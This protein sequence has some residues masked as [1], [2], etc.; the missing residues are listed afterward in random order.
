MAGSS[1]ARTAWGPGPTWQATI[2]ASGNGNN[3]LIAGVPGARIV[4]ILGDLIASGAVTVT[5]Q[6]SGGT[7]L[8]GP[9]SPAANGGKIYP[10]TERGHF[11]T[12]TGEGLVLNLSGSVQVGGHL[13]YAVVPTP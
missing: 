12:L 9:F 11:A 3:T 6:S 4:V 13:I 8:D 10:D 5:M 7:V 2:N 1:H